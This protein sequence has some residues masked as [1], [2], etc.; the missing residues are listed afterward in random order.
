MKKVL[1]FLFLFVFI[2]LNTNADVKLSV[3]YDL[4]VEELNKEEKDLLIIINDYTREFINQ[5][6]Y[7]DKHELIKKYNSAIIKYLKFLEKNNY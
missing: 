5:K 4:D 6:S 2:S 3:P 1:F 7:K